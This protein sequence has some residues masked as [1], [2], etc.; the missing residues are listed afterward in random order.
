[1]LGV[2]TNVLLRAL[3]RDDAKQTDVA[4]KFF[5]TLTPTS[6]GYVNLIVLCEVVWALRS[7]YGY[8]RIQIAEAVAAILSMRELTVENARGAEL[9]LD[10]YQATDIDFADALIVVH[11]QMQGCTTTV[12]FDRALADTSLGRLP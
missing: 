9:A 5:N 12:T 4:R 3:V 8:S 11:N 10:I 2:D 1:M 7:A 6:G